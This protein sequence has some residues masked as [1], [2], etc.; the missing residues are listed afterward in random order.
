MLSAFN[1]SPPEPAALDPELPPELDSDVAVAALPPLGE[2][3]TPAPELGSLGACADATPA[4]AQRIAM[5]A[6]TT[7]SAAGRLPLAPGCKRASHP[8]LALA[9]KSGLLFLGPT[10]L[11][12]GLALKELRYGRRPIRP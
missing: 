2:L 9:L 1:R 3:V 12:V 8:F 11:A 5:I 7:T 10:G 6:T 4:V